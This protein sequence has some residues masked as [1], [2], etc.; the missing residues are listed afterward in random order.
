MA[1]TVYTA[2][3]LYLVQ[4][5]WAGADP[6]VLLIDDAGTYTPDKDHDQLSDLSLGSNELSTTNY[7]RVALTTQTEAADNVDNEVVLDADNV[8]FSALGPNTGGPAVGA[9]VVYFYVDGT[10]ANDIPFLYLDSGFPKQT[11]GED[12]TLVWNAEGIVNLLQ[13]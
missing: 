11:N 9:A 8:V 12:F 1:D 2:G 3:I 4:N 7:A 10:A 6:R 5:G 13:P